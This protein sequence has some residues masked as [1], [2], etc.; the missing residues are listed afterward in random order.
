GDQFFPLVM[1]P[2]GRQVRLRRAD[3]QLVPPGSGGPLPKA[4]SQVL[5]LVDPGHGGVQD[6]AIGVDGSR[7]ADRVLAL[8][9]EVSRLLAARVGRVYL[10]R[11]RD[12][13]ETLKFRVAL[14]DALR[15]DV[16]VSV[17][18]NADPDGRLDRPGVETYGSV[19][20][21]QG[22]RLAGVMYE[23]ERRFLQTVP[24]PWQGD[25]DAGAK[26]RIGRAGGDYYGLLRRA[27]LPWVIS[28]SLF[29]TS[30][31]DMRLLDQ[32]SVQRGLAT[33]IADGARDFATSRVSGSGWTKPYPR[34]PNPA[35]AGSERP[36]VDPVR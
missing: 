34:L 17:H 5:V 18:L 11:T 28:E 27:H 22:R 26:F 1:T 4:A 16:A 15:A 10:T 3:L 35:P 8:G 14:G 32:A 36:C 29:M 7:E 24:G 33:A 9:T 25:T 6:G 12:V 31:H 19:A 23:A 2:C 13:T 30:A 20:D 21:P